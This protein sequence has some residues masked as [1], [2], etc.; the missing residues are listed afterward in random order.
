M[1]TLRSQYKFHLQKQNEQESVSVFL[2]A[3]HALLIDCQ[4]QNA[5]EQRR[6]LAHHLVLGCRNKETLQ[7]L[8]IIGEPNF[9]CMYDLMVAEERANVGTAA[10]QGGAIWKFGMVGTLAN[11]PSNK[12]KWGT[13]V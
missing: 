9:N 3:L 10:V 11:Q 8:F 4:V 12:F 1:N 2:G 6:L 13:H 7:K 5:D